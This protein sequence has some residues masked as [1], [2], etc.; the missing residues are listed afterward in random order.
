ML[1]RLREGANLPSLHT[2]QFRH[3][4]A[5]AAL[6]SGMPE[7]VL[8]MLAGW[9]KNVSETYYRTLNVEDAQRFHARMSPADNLG[10]GSKSSK[11]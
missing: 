6:W 8:R 5:M 9:R 2:H 10:G 1:K 3:T 11:R 7:E 4:F